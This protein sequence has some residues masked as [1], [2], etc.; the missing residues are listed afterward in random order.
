VK[1]PHFRPFDYVIFILTLTLTALSAIAAYSGSGE[2][3]VRIA[4]AGRLWLYPLTSTVTLTVPGPLGDTTVTIA[5]GSARI[6]ASPCPNQ[7]C[8]HSPPAHRSGHAIVCLP[9]HVSV[10]VEPPKAAARR[11]PYA[12]TP[13]PDIVTW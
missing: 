6:S 3:V 10:S 8:V 12:S 5:D 13:S 4:G 11:A 1:A 7:S 9:T 2:P